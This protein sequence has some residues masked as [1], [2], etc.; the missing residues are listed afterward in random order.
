MT[1]LSKIELDVLFMIM[2]GCHEEVTRGAAIGVALEGLQGC[3]LVANVGRPH[4]LRY[5]MTRKGEKA[6]HEHLAKL[7]RKAAEMGPLGDE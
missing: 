3:G 1:E 2:A 7:G 6:V 5:R 4:L